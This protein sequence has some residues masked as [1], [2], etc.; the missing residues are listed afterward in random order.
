M[1]RFIS[2][3]QHIQGTQ[4]VCLL[5]DAHAIDIEFMLQFNDRYIYTSFAQADTGRK[6]TDTTADD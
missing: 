5:D 4:C 3:A 1:H 6:T 2:N